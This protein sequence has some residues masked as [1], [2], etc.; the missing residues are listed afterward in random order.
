M[1]KEKLKCKNIFL[2]TSVF[3]KNNILEG[4]NLKLLLKNAE[5][6]WINLY[7]N[8]II[9]Q[10]IKGRIKKRFQESKSAIKKFLKDNETSI[11]IFRNSDSSKWLEILKKGIDYNSEVSKLCDKIDKLVTDI[12]IELIPYNTVD[13]KSIFDKYFKEEAPFKE[14]AKKSEFPDA[15]VLASI[16]KWCK[17][18]KQQMIILSLDKDWLGYKS[19]SIIP[20]NDISTILEFVVSMKTSMDSRVVFVDR[21]FERNQNQIKKLISKT[22]NK[23]VYFEARDDSDIERYKVS[24]VSISDQSLIDIEEEYAEYYVGVFF[25]ISADIRYEDYDNAYYD[26]ETGEYLFLET[27][28]TTIEREEL[29]TQ[30]VLSISYTVDDISDFDLSIISVNDNKSID[31]EKDDI[32]D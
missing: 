22:L 19:S 20:I 25:D 11:R 15:F 21:L 10:E 18:H 14:G 4:T 7:S 26:N 24:N 30:L 6:G 32:Y 29:H 5:D 23:D 16:E 1:K 9:I 12:P 3:E 27:V 8:D 2:D 13:V 31:I 17:E 28:R